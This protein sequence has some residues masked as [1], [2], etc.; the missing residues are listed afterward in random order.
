M[1]N[2]FKNKYH[3]VFIL[4]VALLFS[5][6]T[7]LTCSC[8]TSFI[9]PGISCFSYYNDGSM[10]YLLGS[11]MVKGYTPY[12]D[13]FDHKGLYIFYYTA[14]G[15][16]LGRTGVFF[17]QMIL[18]TFGFFFIYKSVELFTKKGAIISI[19][20]CL[21]AAIYAF[22]GQTPNDSDL[23]LPFNVLMI[24]FYLRA[25]KNNSHKDF[26]KANVFC[27]ISAGIA[28]NLRVSDAL[29]PFAF[30]VFFLVY[31][32]IHKEY[33]RLFINAGIVVMMMALMSVPPFF[34]AY[35]GGFMNDMVESVYLSNFKYITTTGDRY[36]GSPIIA[37]I[38]VPTILVIFFL[39][40]WFKRKQYNRDFILYFAFTST[41][42]L[43]IELVI[44]FYPHYF[45]VLYPYLAITLAVLL[46]PYLEKEE[47]MSKA[48]KPVVLGFA[49]LLSLSY[50]FNPVLYSVNKSVD[51]ANI[52]YINKNINEEGKNGHT[53]IFAE[54][55]L[56]IAT[57]I[58]I[59]YGDFSCQ[60]NHVM[61]SSRYSRTALVNYLDSNESSYV[62]TNEAEKK[63]VL[64]LFNDLKSSSYQEV[65]IQQN[66]SLTIYRRISL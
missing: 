32:I 36:G 49:I 59:G 30:V 5:F 17:V 9:Y 27:G 47:G 25:L 42:S 50:V 3:H 13:I 45:I 16:L 57:D 29:L 40:I 55:A 12:I 44:A 14:I 34:H 66:S 6:F 46:I 19:G 22:T 31:S 65:P 63:F 41:V 52:A 51:E 23:E 21:F 20:L 43:L 10:F 58:K 38:L 39:L 1:F 4:C 64:S 2:T 35:L 26:L 24:Y 8:V 53:L 7:L 54:S 15:G 11:N 37:Y 60:S 48:Y 61:F 56:Y 18:L 33:K 62:V 28:L